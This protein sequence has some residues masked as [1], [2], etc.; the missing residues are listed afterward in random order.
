MGVTP[1]AI[2][3]ISFS[4]GEEELR[5]LTPGQTTGDFAAWSY[6]QSLDMPENRRFVEAFKKSMVNSVS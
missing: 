4:I 1:E 3:T 6:F 2:S 5:R